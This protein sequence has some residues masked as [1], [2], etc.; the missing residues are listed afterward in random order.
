[1]HISPKPVL[2]ISKDNISK[3]DSLRGYNFI[4]FKGN[5]LVLLGKT[6][7]PHRIDKTLDKSLYRGGNPHLTSWFCKDELGPNFQQVLTM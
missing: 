5:S 2:F 7:V 1:M 3:R 4:Y 6:Q